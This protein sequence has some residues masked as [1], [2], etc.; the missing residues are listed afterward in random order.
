MY[1]GACSCTTALLKVQEAVSSVVLLDG[2]FTDACCLTLQQ[3]VLDNM[4]NIQARHSL[5]SGA[6]VCKCVQAE[7]CC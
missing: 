7:S 2:M 5:M 1:Q 6:E 4:M 3:I